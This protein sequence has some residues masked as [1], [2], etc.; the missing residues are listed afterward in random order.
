MWGRRN[1]HQSTVSCWLAMKLSRRGSPVSTFTSFPRSVR[2]DLAHPSTFTSATEKQKTCLITNFAKAC[3]LYEVYVCIS[4]A[5]TICLSVCLC[6][7]VSV[8]PS[9][10]LSV[11]LSVCVCCYCWPSW[12]PSQFIVFIPISSQVVYDE[13]RL[14]SRMMRT[15]QAFLVSPCTPDGLP[16]CRHIPTLD[17]MVVEDWMPTNVVGQVLPLLVA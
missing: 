6:V 9:V 5:L 16:L 17:A 11:C 12:L 7:C 15:V 13:F 14:S 1:P 4:P 8:C 3:C 2:W 10:C